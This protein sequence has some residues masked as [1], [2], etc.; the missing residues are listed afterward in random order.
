MLSKLTK[1]C[2]FAIGILLNLLGAF[3]CLDA[4]IFN[5]RLRFLLGLLLITSGVLLVRTSRLK[6]PPTDQ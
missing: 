6:K 3:L 1:Y 2:F 4:V 5:D